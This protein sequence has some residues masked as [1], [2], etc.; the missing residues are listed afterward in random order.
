MAAPKRQ[1]AGEPAE[2]RAQTARPKLKVVAP[3]EELEATEETLISRWAEQ[4]SGAILLCR[5]YGHKFPDDQLMRLYRINL[6]W[7][8]RELQCERCHS[9]R[10]DVVA[11]GSLA[12]FRRQ[13]EYVQGYQREKGADGRQR[14]PRWTV[15]EVL[16]Q[17]IDYLTPPD[18]IRELFQNVRL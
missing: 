2:G 18:H 11:N 6:N 16:E 7:S 3:P 12:V 13:Y 15:S 1:T 8:V 5:K 4:A 14:L 10:R 9:T 17:R